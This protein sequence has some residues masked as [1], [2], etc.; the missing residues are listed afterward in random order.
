MCI[1]HECILYVSVHYTWM[2]TICECVLYVN[3]YYMWVCIICECILYVS[4][5]YMWVHIICEWVLYMSVCYTWQISEF[6]LSTYIGW[7]TSNTIIMYFETTSN[8]VYTSSCILF[9]YI[10]QYLFVT[11]L[12]FTGNSIS[13]LQKMIK[14]F[15]TIL[16]GSLNKGQTH[17]KHL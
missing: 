13:N 15:F 2:H 5:Y 12:I 4:V 14:Y 17:I 11:C 10:I 8:A 1:I 16:S 7:S 9:D 3:A 6:L